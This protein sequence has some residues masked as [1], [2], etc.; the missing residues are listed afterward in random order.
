MRVE[1]VKAKFTQNG[2]NQTNGAEVQGVRFILYYHDECWE[3]LKSG[4]QHLG[5]VC[6]TLKPWWTVQV[7]E[8]GEAEGLAYF[9][10][11]KTQ[12]P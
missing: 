4:L 10:E 3:G 12:I 5:L 9:D 7:E 2:I 8:L 11:T 1:K 6:R